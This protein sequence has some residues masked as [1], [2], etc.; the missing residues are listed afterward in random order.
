MMG[1]HYSEDMMEVVVADDMHDGV[2]DA[3]MLTETIAPILT[4][5]ILILVAGWVATTWLKLRHKERERREDRASAASSEQRNT[6]LTRENADLRQQV[7]FVKDRV[8]VLE[9]IVTDRGFDVA[10]QIEA[11]RGPT[12]VQI[13]RL[14]DTKESA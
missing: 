10:S 3:M 4:A 9:R 6:E 11:L 2:I 1:A 8:S 5:L 13:E 7:A 12:N 14:S